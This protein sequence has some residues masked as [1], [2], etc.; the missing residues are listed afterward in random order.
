MTQHKPASKRSHGYAIKFTGARG[1]KVTRVACA[2]AGC[3]M[4][5]ALSQWKG[6]QKTSIYCHAHKKQRERG[7]TLRPFVP[8]SDV[9][10]AWA[11]WAEIRAVQRPIGLGIV[12]EECG[13]PMKVTATR[14]NGAPV[15]Y[16][17]C[18]NC[19]VRVVVGDDGTQ[20][21]PRATRMVYR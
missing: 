1:N 5:P 16:C 2:F 21:P 14:P 20:R 18:D 6:R 11:R 4:P 13:Q 10:A 19:C 15:R 8:R 3:P 7:E 12:H 9:G 17:W